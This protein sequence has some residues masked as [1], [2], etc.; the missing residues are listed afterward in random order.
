[1]YFCWIPWEVARMTHDSA[2]FSLGTFRSEWMSKPGNKN[3]FDTKLRMPVHVSRR[4][5]YEPI[6]IYI[7]LIYIYIS[8]YI[9]IHFWYYIICLKCRFIYI[10]I[11]IHLIKTLDSNIL[12]N[13][14]HINNILKLW[15]PD[16]Y[17]YPLVICYIAIENC[18]RNSRLTHQKWWFS[19]VMYTFTR[20]ISSCLCG[21][22]I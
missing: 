19:I 17:W 1:M 6:Y 16:V 7:L 13:T 11:Y 9:Y 4:L 21:N 10:Y 22:L 14:L 8:I 5:L 20:G 18:H 3:W 2:A 12:R 15:F